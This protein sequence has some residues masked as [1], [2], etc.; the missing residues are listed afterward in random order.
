M[1]EKLEKVEGRALW[2]PGMPRREVLEAS[3]ASARSEEWDLLQ[4]RREEFGMPLLTR[5]ELREWSR[6]QDEEVREHALSR[7]APTWKNLPAALL[8]EVG[9]DYSGCPIVDGEI[10]P[11]PQGRALTVPYLDEHGDLYVQ[12]AYTRKDGREFP[13][14]RAVRRYVRD[15]NGGCELRWPFGYKAKEGP[16]YTPFRQTPLHER[17]GRALLVCEGES[18][19]LAAGL[20]A[21]EEDMNVDVIGVPGASVLP[22][23]LVEYCRGYGCVYQGGDGDQAGRDLNAKI[24]QALRAAGLET[25]A[26]PITE[27]EDIRSLL[28]SG[29]CLSHL[30]DDADELAASGEAPDAQTSLGTAAPPSRPPSSPSAPHVPSH[31]LDAQR[32]AEALGDAT[33][34]SDGSCMAHCPAHDDNRPSLHLTDSGDKLLVHCHAGCSQEE[35]IDALR[36]LGLWGSDPGWRQA[37]TGTEAGSPA[38]ALPATPEERFAAH[39]RPVVDTDPERLPALLE[40][41]CGTVTII[42]AGK[43]HIIHGKPGTGKTWDALLA[44]I[45]AGRVLWCDFDDKPATLAKRAELLR[46]DNILD[47]ERTKYVGLSLFEDPVAIIGAQNWIAESDPDSGPEMN[48]VILDSAERA[49]CLGDVADVA[50][51]FEEFVKPW[52]DVGVTV[53]I[54]DHV[55]KS[56]ENPTRGPIGS[57]FKLA[58]ID[59]ASILVEG[60][61]WTK[62]EPGRIDLIVHKDRAGDMPAAGNR[63]ATIIGDYDENGAFRVSIVAPGDKPGFDELGFDELE[64]R[65]L[66]SVHDHGG[67]D[68]N[69]ALTTNTKGRDSDITEAADKLVERGLLERIKQGRGK[70]TQ[71]RLADAGKEHLQKGLPSSAGVCPPSGRPAEHETAGSAQGPTAPEGA[72]AGQSTDGC[73]SE[74]PAEPPG[75]A[76]PSADPEQGPDTPRL[77]LL[78]AVADCEA[79]GMARTVEELAELAGQDPGQVAAYLEPNP[80]EWKRDVD[81]AG[82]VRY[83]LGITEEELRDITGR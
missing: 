73:L 18:D 70:G 15:E 5:E 13:A 21:R 26:V 57:Q 58:R 22:D 51:W 76:G 4:E 64:H 72:G 66:Q 47:P 3:K 83:I 27:G 44:A 63:L 43:T 34:L 69:K 38:A 11:P 56:D 16:P 42:Y 36:E 29:V 41:D 25:R 46:A 17:A 23:R 54:I 79:P 28:D 35:V 50:K 48:L 6:R 82:T 20:A 31:R 67:F 65:V 49:G 39:V 80:G 24:T 7:L 59:G 45:R 30:F 55:P 12:P 78:H 2:G 32:I 62:D 60:T 77:A 75:S 33:R 68:S 9:I 53:I 14:I 1:S 61:P 19:T 40:S 10:Q 71:W 37:A 8:D 74:N 81:S 52:E